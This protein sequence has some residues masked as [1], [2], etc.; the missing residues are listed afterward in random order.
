MAKI[1][2]QADGSILS[3]HK[4]VR[5]PRFPQYE[6]EQRLA[7]AK[8]LMGKYGID[9]LLLFSPENIYYYTGFKKE[10]FALDKRWRRGAIILKD[11]DPIMLMGNEVFFNATLTSWV[12][13][14][15]GWG[16]PPELGRPQNFVEAYV[17]LIQE[18]DLHQKVLGMEIWE[19]S[20][21]IPV[22]LTYLEFDQLRNNL[23]DAKIV[24]AGE[25]IWKQRMVKTAWEMETIREL[26]AITTKGFIAGLEAIRE[27]I[28]ERDIVRKI[29]KVMIGSGLNNEPM[30]NR[31]LIR[32]PGHYHADMMGPHDTVLKMGDMLQFDGG[33]CHKGYW[34]DV[35]RNACVGEPPNL[36]K[37]LYDIALEVQQAAI[38]AVKPGATVGSVYMAAAEKLKRID[39]GDDSKRCL[40][41]GHGLGIHPHEPPCFVPSGKESDT[42]L[43]EAMYL[44][45]EASAYDAPEFKVIGGFPGD[46][47]LVTKDG[48]ENLTKDIPNHLWIA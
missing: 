33:P 10:N 32:G 21:T 6:F 1:E 22:D 34:C 16:G 28:T 46:S 17:Q 48:C 41:G 36:Q 30:P 24:D 7:K 15:K 44:V 3:F 47:I 13:N 9:A 11:A 27:G 20:A 26:A 35:K 37:R 42:V 12:D 5:F 18:L 23:L 40:I 4:E 39:S 38:N 14:I 31:M 19:G 2:K 43:E 8:E 45:I 25:L 29:Y